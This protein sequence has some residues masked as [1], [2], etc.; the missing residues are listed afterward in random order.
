MLN[1]WTAKKKTSV[2][3]KRLEGFDKPARERNTCMYIRGLRYTPCIHI[4]HHPTYSNLD[5]LHI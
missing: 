4:Q 2:C 1:A 3:V 5:E